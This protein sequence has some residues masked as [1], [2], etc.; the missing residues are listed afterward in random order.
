MLREAKIASNT[1]QIKVNFKQFFDDFLVYGGASESRPYVVP[2]SSSG[3]LS[4]VFFNKNVAGSYAPSSVRQ[5]HAFT[6]VV[7]ISGNK[8]LVRYSLIASHSTLALKHLLYGQRI[9]IIP[10]AVF[11]YRNYGLAGAGE[12]ADFQLFV[13]EFRA[14]FGFNDLNGAASFDELFDTNFLYHNDIRTMSTI[15]IGEMN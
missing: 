6:Q 4:N 8:N 13:S 9:P 14:E 10:L 3:G 12:A 5:G 11:I 7:S 2:F 15:N 1:Q